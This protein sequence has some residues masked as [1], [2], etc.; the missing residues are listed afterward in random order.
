MA[1]KIYFLED[2]LMKTVFIKYN[3]YKLQTEITIEGKKLAENSKLGEK[4][5]EGSRLQE[6]IEEFP[7]ILFEEYNDTSFDITFHGTTLDYEDLSDVF[8]DIEEKENIKVKLTHIPAKETHHKEILIDKV[9]QKIK[10]VL[11]IKCWEVGADI[12]DIL[13]IWIIFIL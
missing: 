13:I 7:Q 4:S 3:P 9:F 1:W 8:K 10:K 6:W 12:G 11:L 5:S 2:D